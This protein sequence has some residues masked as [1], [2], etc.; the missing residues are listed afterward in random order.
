MFMCS[1]MI[2]ASPNAKFGLPEVS[3]GLY[4][5]AGGLSR[6]VRL[7]G[8]NLASEIA[9]AGRKINAQEAV[10]H[11]IANRVSRTHE[12]LLDEAVEMAKAIADLS[13]DAIIV[14]RSGLRQ[15]LET[16]SVERASQITHDRYGKALAEGKNMI[17]GLD[18]FAKKKKPDW[19]ASKL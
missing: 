7:V 17:I 15:A 5:A 11:G 10:Q 9:M 4:A 8:I 2:V 12:S 19:V 14:T 13:P 1:D 16:G 6:L 18:A 3:R